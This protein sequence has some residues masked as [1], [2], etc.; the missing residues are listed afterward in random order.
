[1][2]AICANS[3]FS[4]TKAALNC[5]EGRNQTT[6]A[7]NRYCDRHTVTSTR[8]VLRV[9]RYALER[10]VG[11]SSPLSPPDLGLATLRYRQNVRHCTRKTAL[12]GTRVPKRPLSVRIVRLN[13]AAQNCR[14]T[15]YAAML[16]FRYLQTLFRSH[17][18]FQSLCTRLPS[19]Y[20]S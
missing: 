7:P 13:T 5:H 4:G 11:V 20:P 14:S 18:N 19:R 17:I 6:N 1:M 2:P 16:Y 3:P 8:I 10:D 9:S 12:P 15:L